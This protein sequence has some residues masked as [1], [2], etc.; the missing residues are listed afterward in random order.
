MDAAGFFNFQ[1]PLTPGRD[2]TSP[3]SRR[4]AITRRMTTG[5]VSTLEAM[6]SEVSSPVPLEASRVRIWSATEK[7]R[8]VV[9]FVTIIVTNMGK[10][11][12]LLGNFMKG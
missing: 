7:R 10:S 9:I 11:S 2:A 8:L 1:P 6:A 12:T 3:L 4:E 5:F